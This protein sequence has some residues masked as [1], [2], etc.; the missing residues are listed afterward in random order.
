MKTHSPCHRHSH[1]P[2]IPCPTNAFTGCCTHPCRAIDTHRTYRT[3]ARERPSTTHVLPFPTPHFYHSPT[4]AVAET[5][6]SQL[7]AVD[8][9]R[10]YE[11]SVGT[12]V[13][14]GNGV[15]ALRESNDRENEH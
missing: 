5:C 1:E 2:N 6:A 9:V 13:E 15:G 7:T 11:V 10:A 4:R 14:K 3:T 8:F 12:A